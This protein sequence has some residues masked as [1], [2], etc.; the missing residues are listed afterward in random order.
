MVLGPVYVL[1]LGDLGVVEAV[2]LKGVDASW[3]V[4]NE[5]RM[6][7]CL[8]RVRL[9][10]KTGRT[11]DA[12]A[13]L[14]ELG[15]ARGTNDESDA[16]IA[17]NGPRILLEHLR[18]CVPEDYDLIAS[19]LTNLASEPSLR[20]AARGDEAD[21]DLRLA[22]TFRIFTA[23]LTTIFALIFSGLVLFIIGFFLGN[24]EFM[25]DELGQ[26]ERRQDEQM[27][28]RCTK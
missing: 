21:H 7:A 23:V 19:A 9:G 26:V 4:I 20:Q 3:V 12:V 28:K 15:G 24:D 16:F 13:A 2:C 27:W 5:E 14:R 18:T 10:Y 17:A 11:D 22:N 8:E 25:D 6:L 1:Q